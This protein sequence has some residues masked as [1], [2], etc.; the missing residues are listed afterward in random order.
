C[1]RET[2]P[3]VEGTKQSRGHVANRSRVGSG[4]CDFEAFPGSLCAAWTGPRL[5]KSTST[6]PSSYR[7]ICRSTYPKTGDKNKPVRLVSQFRHRGQDW[8]LLASAPCRSQ[9]AKPFL[10]F[11]SSPSTLPS[12]HPVVFAARFVLV[13]E[14]R[15]HVRPI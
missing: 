3:D 8:N 2:E 7:A 1:Y 9:R 11:S 10:L 5:D 12:C 13:L 4:V 14:F 6:P 15:R